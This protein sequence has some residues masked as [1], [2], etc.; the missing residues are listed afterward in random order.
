MREKSYISKRNSHTPNDIQGGEKKVMKKGLSLLLAAS[1][2]ASAFSTA[3]F[4]ADEELTAQ[5]KYDALVEAGIFDGMPDGQAH[6]DENMTRAQA[7]KIVT[8]VL[9]L[10]ENASAASIY[11]DLAEAEWAKGFIGAATEAGILNGRGN[12]VFDPSANVSVQEL[13]KIMVE[14]LDLEVDATA[15]AEGAD[16]WAQPYVA[17]AI[18]A[19]IIPESSDYTAAAS[20]ELLVEASYVAKDQVVPVGAVA[21]TSAKATGVSKVTVEFNKPIDTESAIFALKKGSTNIATTVDFAEDKRSATLNLTDTKI[22]AGDYTVTVSGLENLDAERAV[23]S[24]TAENERITNLDFLTASDTIAYATS[25]VV[26]AA[27]L[28]QYGEPA[29]TN[30]GS[31]NIY[32]SGAAFKKITKADDGT[33]LI[34]LDTINGDQTQQGVSVIPVTLVNTDNHM[35]AT[36]NFKL[37]TAP[38]LSKAA[39]G[40]ARYSTGEALGGKGENVKFD[41]FFYDQYGNEIAYEAYESLGF[42][43]NDSLIWNTYLSSEDVDW[44]IEDNGNNIP[45]L[46]INLVNNVDKSGEYSFTVFN[47]AANATGTIVIESSKIATKVQI[48]DVENVL[49]AGDENVYVPIIAYDAQGNELSIEDL[50]SDQNVDRITVSLS[51][52]T[53]NGGSSSVKIEKTGADKGKV[54]LANVTAGPNGAVSITAVIATANAQSTSTKTFTVQDARTPDRIKEITAPVA[55]IAIGG[56]KNT[57]STSSNTTQKFQFNVLDQYGGKLKKALDVTSNGASVSNGIDYDV[58]VTATTYNADGQPVSN[59]N[60][61]I[62]ALEVLDENDDPVVLSSTPLKFGN[63][64]D[65]SATDPFDTEHTL[66]LFNKEFRVTATNAANTTN[67]DRVV[68]TARITK[69]GTEIAKVSKTIELLD[70]DDSLNYTV[71][72][73]SAIFNAKDNA[74]SKNEAAFTAVTTSKLAHEVKVEAT[75]AGDKVALPGSIVSITSSDIGVAEVGINA[76]N[77]AYVLGNKT[78]TATLNVVYRTIKGETKQTTV[79]V[80][81]KSDA[82]SVASMTAGNDEFLTATAGVTTA[83][84]AMDLEVVDNY[85]K[86]Y[87]VAA[88]IVTY[89]PLL[90]ITYSVQNVTG[91]TVNVNPTTGVITGTVNATFDLVATSPSGK[92]AVTSV[93]ISN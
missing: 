28:N 58:T 12:G 13:A 76:D 87:D 21:V 62:E 51:G 72:T 26:K 83:P 67:E 23:A 3:A 16:E 46:R 31:Y 65:T 40:D 79:P 33:L 78:G 75:K 47:Q 61:Y 50:T 29:S 11:D 36:K 35:T 70:A 44:K 49:A 73:A 91:G 43:V 24:F 66:D 85:G 38:I 92:S 10:D 37:G 48:G 52:A 30:A 25:V 39:L 14:L 54:K 41:L 63:D 80:T 32:T 69:D 71:S 20:R 56:T 4:A 27:A 55:A 45:Q 9:G 77:K 88:D 22:S 82:I 1:M 15:T 59:A 81:V 93:K 74:A 89:N 34:T 84:E 17:A 60:L 2:A 6:L 19:G 64:I 7:A 18:E 90:G 86:K 57:D 42:D 8:K 68:F 53:G 5:E